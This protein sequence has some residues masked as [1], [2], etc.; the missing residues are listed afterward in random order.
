MVM[1][2]HVCVHMYVNGACLGLF[3]VKTCQSIMCK[4]DAVYWWLGVQLLRWLQWS[5]APEESAFAFTLLSF[6]FP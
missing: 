2:V 1:Y 4:E 5:S 3:S 6:C